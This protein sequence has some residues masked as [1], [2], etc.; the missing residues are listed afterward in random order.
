M[1]HALPLLVLLVL[2][3]VAFPRLAEAQRSCTDRPRFDEGG[4]GPPV[5]VTPDHDRAGGGAL[6]GGAAAYMETER[7]RRIPVRAPLALPIPGFALFAPSA[8]RV[9][10]SPADVSARSETEAA[11][12]R[13]APRAGVVRART[14]MVYYEVE[15]KSRAALAA[16]LQA[17]GPDL[18]GRRFFGMTEW[19]VSAGYLP[20][21]RAS[22]CAIDDLT[23]EVA[24][25]THLPRWNR[26]ASVPESLSGAWSQFLRALVQHERGHRM[27]AEEA[28]E[29]IRH[30]LSAASAS[31]CD[32]LDA[33]AQRVM[34]SVM[35]EYE[36]RN[37]AY[38]A[39]TNHGRTQGAVW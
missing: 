15:G 25:K 29:A 18:H 21:K 28:A 38:D 5:V 31:S 26:S 9:A 2:L 8:S 39:E 19:E 35:Q 24:I 6:G 30:R 20:A 3:L 27:L 14:A 37:R 36:S 23:V 34:V 32:R 33:T 22:A 10:P 12:P 13:V 4:L 7:V 17:H 11:A 16:A 1:R